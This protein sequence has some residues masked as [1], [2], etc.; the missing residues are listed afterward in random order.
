MIINEK[1]I[2]ICDKHHHVLKFWYSQKSENLY[3]LTFDH[4]TDLHRAYQGELNKFPYKAKNQNDWDL[5]QRKLLETLIEND[6]KDI[7]LLHHDEHIDA[8]ILLNIF[9]KILVYSYD[10]YCNKPKRVYCITDKEY[11]NQKVI[12]NYNYPDSDY[13]IE[14]EMLI[15]NFKKIEVCNLG[16]DVWIDNFILDIDLDFFKTKKSINPENVDFFKYL[17]S[18][19][20]AITIATEPTFVNSL[21]EDEDLNSEYLLESLLNLIKTV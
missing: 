19:C 6:F 7:N 17:I 5:E 16:V 9:E 10:S 18:K 1:P 21:K 20:K 4:H 12:N 15:N 2:F 3:L 13:V 11:E 14:S 8:S